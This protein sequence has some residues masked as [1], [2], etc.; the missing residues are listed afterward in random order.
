VLQIK[1]AE[2]PKFGS[3]VIND[4]GSGK[5]TGV[6]AGTADNDAVNVLQLK[7]IQDIANAGWKLSAQADAATMTSVGPG[8]RVD[9]SNTDGNLVVEKTAASDDVTFDLAKDITVDSVTMGDTVVNTAGLTIANGP[10]ITVN[11]IDAG[12]KAITGVAAGSV[13][14]TS[15]EA[16][17][18]SQLFA[19]N[20][21]IED[22]G[23][24][25]GNANDLAVKYGWSD[26]NGDGI[27]TSDEIDYGTVTLAGAN[28]AGTRIDNVAPG[29]LD[30]GSMQA[31]N[32]SQ[33]FQ[34]MSQVAAMLGGGA[35]MTSQGLTAPSYF[36]QNTTYSDVGSALQALDIAVTRID[37]RPVIG[38]SD[39][40]GYTHGVE[41]GY[42]PSGNGGSSSTALGV[43]A[44][45]TGVEDA[46]AVGESATV[47]A[48]YGTALGQN[49]SVTA[50]G[51]VAL[52]HNSV[53]D[54]ADTVSVGSAG[55]ERQVV[56]VA[57]ATQGTDAINKRQLD[58]GVASANSYTDARVNALSD[59]FDLFQGAVDERLRRQDRR[60]DRQGA[61]NAAMMNMAMSAAGIH[62][63][64]R[65]GVGIG[66]QGG[67]S[68]MSLGYQ[69][70]LSERAT[71]T[72]G[73]AFSSDDSSVGLGAGFGW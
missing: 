33:L 65:V 49:A 72:F 31:I 36:I 48:A 24:V 6:T 53:A 38:G 47:G 28:G 30:L 50:E 22:L 18:G 70:A 2:S 66:F 15:T 14:D 51:A 41:G 56:N 12:G 16:I 58:R 37:G 27:A 35:T 52:G 11:G 5:I 55:A 9:L 63:E 73:G 19:T 54:R 67:Q 44:H 61:M 40:V 10:S 59:S 64:N 3:V 26:T 25:A 62:T 29:L 8:E 34:S 32:G 39:L 45:A 17:N 7:G 71:I 1:M 23:S 4:G 69:R 13:T 46:V 57:D 20:K 43:N 68:A 42:T 60:I 21:A